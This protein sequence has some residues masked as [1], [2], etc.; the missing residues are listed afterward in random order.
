MN[1]NAIFSTIT[2]EECEVNG[3]RN[4]SGGYAPPNE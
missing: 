3:E 1:E 2:F 4:C